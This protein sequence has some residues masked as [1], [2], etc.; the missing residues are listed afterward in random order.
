MTN[1]RTFVIGDVHGDSAALE[2]L[3]DRL[4]RID[5]DDTI[6]FLG[7][8]VDRGPDSAG[9][10]ARVRAIAAQ[11]A[12]TVT[13]R[14]NHEDKWIDCYEEP[15]AG[16]LLPRSN[17][18]FE[19]FRSFTGGPVPAREESPSAEEFPRFAN[20][21]SWLPADVYEWMRSL[22]H[23]Y[24][25]EHAIYVHAGLEGEGKIWFHPRDSKPKPL[26]W[27]REPDFYVGYA[28]KRVVFGHTVTKELPI[29]HLGPIK[30][31]FDDP[32]D[33]WTRGD[34]V[35]IDTGCGKGG[36]LSAVELPRM[37]VYESR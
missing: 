5:D 23:W 17:G 25:D 7:D 4:P 22:P 6:V 1:A 28:G 31:L 13:L 26:L 15:D 9:V 24:E 34:L 11:H 36:F 12:R 16:F 27:M 10:I 20:V 33:V 32:G 21:R 37:K 35:G 18:C 19:M 8:Y 30:R 2:R 29:D 3:L 14:G